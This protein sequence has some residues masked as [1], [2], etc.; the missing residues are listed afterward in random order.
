MWIN[1]V[2][3]RSLPLQ[4]MDTLG[5][6]TPLLPAHHLSARVDLLDLLAVA[7]REVEC[8]RPR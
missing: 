1:Q 7:I 8:R 3:L 5:T 2:L 6:H 4:S